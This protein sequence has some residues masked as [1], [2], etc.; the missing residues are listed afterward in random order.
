MNTWS[1]VVPKS[2]LD[3]ALHVEGNIVDRT[4]PPHH[5][6]PMKDGA[7]V[8]VANKSREKIRKGDPDVSGNLE[9]NCKQKQKGEQ[10]RSGTGRSA[11]ESEA[12]RERKQSG[13]KRS[14]SKAQW[15]KK[16]LTIGPRIVGHSEA[17]LWINA[18]V[19]GP[20]PLRN[21]D[22]SDGDRIGAKPL[23]GEFGVADFV[24]GLWVDQEDLKGIREWSPPNKSRHGGPPL[25]LSL[26]LEE[27]HNRWLVLK[28]CQEPIE[29]I[30]NE[31]SERL[32]LFRKRNLTI[33]A[34]SFELIKGDPRGGLDVLFGAE[35]LLKSGN[36]LDRLGVLV[37][38]SFKSGCIRKS[39]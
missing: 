38:G 12:K 2:S 18:W 4:L 1:N 10:K 19:E 22:L 27:T 31:Q 32:K 39:S 8:K 25:K 13:A 6:E 34:A 9:L 20:F 30:Q 29:L 28:L 15:Q 7:R 35:D 16:T 14:A 24:A 21:R 26:A 17:L 33:F 3:L 5:D 23:L 37:L 36:V 11:S